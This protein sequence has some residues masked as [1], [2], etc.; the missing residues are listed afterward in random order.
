M[1]PYLEFPM[2]ERRGT[3]GHWE[4]EGRGG[5]CAGRGKG[6]ED[7][8]GEEIGKDK[9]IRQNSPVLEGHPVWRK[10]LY[11]PA[12]HTPASINLGNVSV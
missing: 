3:Q 1:F 7:R 12:H 8:P 2:V 11:N 10:P 6:K 4:G 5:H 9:V